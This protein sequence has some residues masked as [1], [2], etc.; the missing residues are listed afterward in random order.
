[1][2]GFNLTQLWISALVGAFAVTAVF[3]AGNHYGP[4]AVWRSHR[5]AEDKAKNA[6]LT[7]MIEHEN[8]IGLQEDARFATE[9]KQF[10]VAA[11]QLPQCVL[12]AATVDALNS[13]GD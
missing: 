5:E 3:L 10:K 9:D 7:D 2:F 4:N 1:M 12:D 13:V 8:S 6:V 11:P